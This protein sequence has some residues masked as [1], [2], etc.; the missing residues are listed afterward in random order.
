M[1]I[2]EMNKPTFVSRYNA[3]YV[4]DRMKEI[5]NRYSSVTLTDILDLS[6]RNSEYCF[7]KYYW[8]KDD[9]ESAKIVWD[10]IVRRYCIVLPPPEMDVSTPDETN[11]TPE[12]IYI[13]IHVK[14]L[15]D[16]D[17]VLAETFKYIYT[18]KDRTVN[19]SIM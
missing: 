13:T 6:G 10:E 2:Y 16:P 11:K 1:N 18:I 8:T 5:I 17:A 12:P 3:E 14:D 7:N 9:V 4:L 19:L 15:D